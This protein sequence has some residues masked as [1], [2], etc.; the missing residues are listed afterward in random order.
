MILT[1]K[2]AIAEC[3]KLWEEI[4]AFGL[5]KNAF[6]KTEK[7]KVWREKEY[8]ADCPLCE[9]DTQKRIPGDYCSQCPLMRK[10]NQSCRDLGCK[11]HSIPSQEWLDA[12]RG[13]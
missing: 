11:E 10:Y 2:K 4:A 8:D 13:L 12:I 7:G 9:Y 1:K 3:K 6:L 5:S